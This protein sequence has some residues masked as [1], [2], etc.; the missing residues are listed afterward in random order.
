[1][2]RQVTGNLEGPGYVRKTNAC[3]QQEPG[4]EL[5]L[6]DDRSSRFRAFHGGSPAIFFRE[7]KQNEDDDELKR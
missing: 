5:G 2:V 7:C 6:P 4:R 1:M 3:T